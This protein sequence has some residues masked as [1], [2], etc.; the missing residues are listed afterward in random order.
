MRGFA[1]NGAM[2]L[3]GPKEGQGLGHGGG[4]PDIGRAS[5]RCADVATGRSGGG[6]EGG[7]GGGGMLDSLSFLGSFGQISEVSVVF[8]YLSFQFLG[9]IF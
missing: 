7:R 2:K 9:F 5:P 6:G 8:I 3:S 1:A 4:G